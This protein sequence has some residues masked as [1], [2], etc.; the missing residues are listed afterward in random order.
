MSINVSKSNQV[1][2][3]K[4]VVVAKITRANNGSGFAHQEGH[5]TKRVEKIKKKNTATAIPPRRNPRLVSNARDS[6]V[7]G[8]N[9]LPAQDTPPPRPP[10]LPPPLEEFP[11]FPNLPLELRLK[12]RSLAEPCAVTIRTPSE[13]MVN[14]EIYTCPS[15]IPA[16]LH[17]C[18][19]SRAEYT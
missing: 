12:I 16:V 5:P 15:G 4:G 8:R 17:A 19:E 1:P 9:C 10:A 13:D 2:A 18:T 6:V 7:L 14:H 3:T 11:L